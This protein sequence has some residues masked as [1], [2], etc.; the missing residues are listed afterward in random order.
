MATF[1]VLSLLS[2]TILYHSIMINIHP[3]PFICVRI[4]ICCRSIRRPALKFNTALLHSLSIWMLKIWREMSPKMDFEALYSSRRV[5]GVLLWS[6]SCCSVVHL[7]VLFL[8]SREGIM[9]AVQLIQCPGLRMV[10]DKC[11]PSSFPPF[12]LDQVYSHNPS[13]SPCSVA[14]FN[15]H[16]MW[17]T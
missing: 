17:G 4:W 10:V 1:F 12:F 13:H 14:L 11:H 2:S 5:N 7:P 15:T 6:F 3:I 16:H 9:W 8:P